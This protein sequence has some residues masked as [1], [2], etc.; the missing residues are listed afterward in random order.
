MTETI[1]KHVAL[2]AL[3]SIAVIGLYFTP[4]TVIDCPTRS[5]IAFLTVVASLLAAIGLALWGVRERARSGTVSTWSLISI[6]ILI[7]PAFLVFGPLA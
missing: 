1:A 7:L 3:A 4:L 6:A 5:L 2:P